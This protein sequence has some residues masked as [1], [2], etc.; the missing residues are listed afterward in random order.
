MSKFRLKSLD[1]PDQELSIDVG[2]DGDISI[3]IW[4]EDERYNGKVGHTVRIGMGPNSGD[5]NENVKDIQYIKGAFRNL[6]R[7]FQYQDGEISEEEIQKYRDAPK[8]PSY[9]EGWFKDED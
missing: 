5:P 1:G 6:A 3:T 4:D 8:V 2:W 7:E 9:L